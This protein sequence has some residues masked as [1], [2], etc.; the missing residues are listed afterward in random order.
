MSRVQI[1][2]VARQ[3][4][5][6]LAGVRRRSIEGVPTE[7]EYDAGVVAWMEH[8]QGRRI[9]IHIPVRIRFQDGTAGFG[10]ATNISQ[11]GMFI[12]TT[13]PW[14]CGCADIFLK[15]DGA[16]REVV[17]RA[18]V[19]HGRDKVTGQTRGGIGLMFR[20]LDEDAE[21]A[22]GRLLAKDARDHQRV[23]PRCTTARRLIS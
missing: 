7:P 21:H 15:P 17:F 10:L 12:R 5:D 18:W 6:S 3:R 22:L 9:D 4:N 11:G 1:N 2:A 8:R 16:D 20:A 23:A 14:R 13:L 19:V